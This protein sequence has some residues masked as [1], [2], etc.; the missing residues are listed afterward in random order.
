MRTVLAALALLS[1]AVASPLVGQGDETL[2]GL[3][4]VYVYVEAIKDEVRRDGLE[5]G[6]I[7]TDVELRLRQAG[8][9][10]LTK[11]QSFDSAGS[12]ILDVDV[13]AAK[14]TAEGVASFYAYHVHI[15]LSQEVRLVRKPSLRVLAATWTGGSTVGVIGADKLRSVRDVLRDQMDKFINAYLAANPKR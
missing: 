12:P 11:Q 9:T 7:R 3:K 14:A 13:H 2:A 1:A 4:G 8:V 6:Q 15:Q 10:V 5:E